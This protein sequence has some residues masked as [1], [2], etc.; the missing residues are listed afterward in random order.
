MHCES[1]VNPARV[2]L[3]VRPAAHAAGGVSHM[4]MTGGFGFSFKKPEAAPHLAP[5]FFS[6]HIKSPHSPFYNR[7]LCGE[8]IYYLR[9]FKG[10]ALSGELYSR[11]E[12]A[13]GKPAQEG[14]PHGKANPAHTY[15]RIP[16]AAEHSHQ[17]QRPWAKPVIS[18]RP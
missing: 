17:P 6:E 8:S 4:R 7:G 3:P 12:Q 11:F 9:Y 1:E 15:P 10:N 5:G 14:K 18:R 16:T 13:P 2:G